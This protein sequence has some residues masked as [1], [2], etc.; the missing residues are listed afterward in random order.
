MQ[1]KGNFIPT[2]LSL[3][4]ILLASMLMLMGG[5]AVA[6][7]LPQIAVAFPQCSTFTVEL[8]VT[9]PSLAI[10]LTGILIG[11]L[12]DR[13]GKVKVLVAS[14]LLF[15]LAGLSGYFL[16]D[17]TLILVGRLFTGVGIAGITC[18]CTALLTVYYSGETRVRVLGYQTATMGIGVLFLETC[19]GAFAGYGW[20]EP[21]LIY[22]IGFIIF[23]MALVSLREPAKQTETATAAPTE[24]Q[25]DRGIIA[26]S[27]VTT[28]CLMMIMF[29]YPTKLAEFMSTYITA[30]PLITGFL[31][32]L[33]GVFNAAFCLMYKHISKH[34][35]PFAVVVI[36]LGL[37][38]CGDL[39]FYF[40]PSVPWIAVCTCI[41]GSG[42]GLG[43]T[44][45][46]NILSRHTSPRSSGKVMGGYTTFFN[47]GQ[48]TATFLV[49]ALVGLMS[50]QDAFVTFGVLALAMCAAFAAVRYR[51]LQRTAP[52]AA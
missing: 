32:G 26:L 47:L 39:L 12:A 20:H 22:G 10:A 37:M 38:G 43:T 41:T 8:I 25:N 51:V 28:F 11:L 35:D 17:I 21:F 49:A 45:V 14:L 7:A 31:L 36:G 33:N 6:P 2:K 50:L 27:Y 24:R 15:G 52:A 9:L 1:S 48:F 13:I 4:T 44:A 3:L 19:G 34:L 5:A 46:V 18:C 30:E 42:V 16:N 40:P 29:L 23:A